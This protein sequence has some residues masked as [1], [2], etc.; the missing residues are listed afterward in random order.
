MTQTHY[1][2]IVPQPVEYLATA[3]ATLDTV[4]VFAGVTYT[5]QFP[6]SAFQAGASLGRVAEINITGTGGTASVSG[7]RMTINMDKGV[8]ARSVSPSVGSYLPVANIDFGAGFLTSFGA[9]TVTVSTT[10]ATPLIGMSN[11]GTGVGIIEN[12]G[13]ANSFTTRSISAGAGISVTQIGSNIQISSVAGA[14]LVGTSGNGLT[15]TANSVALALAS[16]SSAGA[17]AQLSGTGTDYFAGDGTFKPLPSAGVSSFNGATGAI[18]WVNGTNTTVVSLGGGQFR[19]DAVGGGGGA[20]TSVTSGNPTALTVSP[21]TGGVVVTPNGQST[22]LGSAWNPTTRILSISAGTY[23]GGILTSSLLNQYDLSV[24]ATSNTVE[25]RK[26]GTVIGQAAILNFTGAGVTV[27]PGVGFEI[28]IPAVSGGG[29]IAGVSVNGVGTYTNLIFN[30]AGVSVSGNQVTVASSGF[31]PAGAQY[32]TLWNN[33]TNWLPTSVIAVSD[34]AGAQNVTI[35]V[36]NTIKLKRQPVTPPPFGVIDE[37]SEIEIGSA[38][39]KIGTTRLGFY[40]STPVGKPFVTTGNLA[41]LETALSNLG[42]INL[43]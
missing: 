23:Q 31:L 25:V 14:G 26:D 29:G 10:A 32:Q 22:T 20:V 41:S 38:G 33:G 5:P 28:N 11:A 40:S 4:P 27:T 16:I 43:I 1:T 17:V 7:K 8:N 21:T 6:V 19:L 9:N 24:A 12:P 2:Q 39:V 3:G 15:V 36:L 35:D 34:S 13:A 18:Q 42:L 37:T 30:G